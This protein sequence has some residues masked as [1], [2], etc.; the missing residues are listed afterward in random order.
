MIVQ[1]LLDNGLVR[2]Y[3]DRGVYVHGGY[4][5]ADYIDPIDPVSA[6]R[7][8]VETNIPIVREEA[9]E[10]NLSELEEKAR[11]FDIL[12]GVSP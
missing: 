8:Y 1:E 3:S 12:M 6:N 9:D 2:T 4:P 10:Q 5:E 11:A 7:V